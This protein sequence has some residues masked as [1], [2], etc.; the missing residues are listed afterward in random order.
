[1]LTNLNHCSYIVTEPTIVHLSFYTSVYFF[2]PADFLL[3]FGL[4]CFQHLKSQLSNVHSCTSMKP[5][6]VAWTHQLQAL[7]E[8]QSH[9]LPFNSPQS[10]SASLWYLILHMAQMFFP[11]FGSASLAGFDTLVGEN[12]NA[13]SLG[14]SINTTGRLGGRLDCTVWVD[15]FVE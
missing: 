15:L 4:Q 6:H 1:M 8:Q 12:A 10:L 9:V 5:K 13:G 11:T 3:N 2:F 7:V 14:A